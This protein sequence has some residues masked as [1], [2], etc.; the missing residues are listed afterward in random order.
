MK[1][2]YQGTCHKMSPKHLPR[3]VREFT[4]LHQICDRYTMA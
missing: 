1:R 2:G 4:G 3:Y